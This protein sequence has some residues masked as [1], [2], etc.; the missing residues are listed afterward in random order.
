MLLIPKKVCSFIKL[1]FVMW[2]QLFGRFLVI[3]KAENISWKG[4]NQT[5]AGHWKNS[6][7]TL[8]TQQIAHY[9]QWISL[10]RMMNQTKG[11][12][13][14]N[15]LLISIQASY[16]NFLFDTLFWLFLIFIVCQSK[17]F[18]IDGRRS[19]I[20]EILLGD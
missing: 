11:C 1:P 3:L 8:T 5:F 4:S 9:G 20:W 14:S 12:L 18:L 17:D 7:N 19:L 15:I 2:L 13:M 10:K 6:K 16:S